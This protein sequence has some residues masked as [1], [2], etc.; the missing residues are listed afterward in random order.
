[1]ILESPLLTHADSAGDLRM[2]ALFNS[3]DREVKE[4]VGLVA[5]ADPRFQFRHVGSLV[6]PVSK[7]GTFEITWQG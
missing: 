6:N 5:K 1:M 7:M 2:M 3:H 4:W